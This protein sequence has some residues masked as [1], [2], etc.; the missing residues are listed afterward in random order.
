MPSPPSL[1]RNLEILCRIGCRLISPT[2]LFHNN[3]LSGNTWRPSRQEVTAFPLDSATLT[4]LIR[5][6]EWRSGGLSTCAPLWMGTRGPLTYL[7]YQLLNEENHV[8]GKNVNI[9]QSTHGQ[10]QRQALFVISD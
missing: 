7:T 9:N 1:L 10:R 4:L 6:Y 2:C 3:R 5:L 8:R